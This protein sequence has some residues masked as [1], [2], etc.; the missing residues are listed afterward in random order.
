MKVNEH[1]FYKC[2]VKLP[3][4]DVNFDRLLNVTIKCSIKN[5]HIHKSPIGK[6]QIRIQVCIHW[7]TSMLHSYLCVTVF[8][9]FSNSDQVNGMSMCEPSRLTEHDANW[10]MPIWWNDEYFTRYSLFIHVRI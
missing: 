1:Q 6:F 7:Q 3:C 10:D 4:L 5:I 8:S 2:I 9:L